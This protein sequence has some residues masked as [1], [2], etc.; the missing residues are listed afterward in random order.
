MIEENPPGKFFVI[1]KIILFIVLA[2]AVGWYIFVGV[3]FFQKNKTANNNVQKIFNL[4][5]KK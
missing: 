3:R 1:L 4:Q 2:I 5:K